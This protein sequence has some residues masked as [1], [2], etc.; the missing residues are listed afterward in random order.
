MLLTEALTWQAMRCVCVLQWKAQ[1]ARQDAG[2]DSDDEEDDSDFDEDQESDDEEDEDEGKSFPHH[3][4]ADASYFSLR[5][6]RNS[7]SLQQVLPRDA[8]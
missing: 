2:G 1:A 5:Y 6:R 7:T 3:L 8:L 4:N